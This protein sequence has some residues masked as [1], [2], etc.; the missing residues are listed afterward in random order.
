MTARRRYSTIHKE[1]AMS[2]TFVEGKQEFVFGDAWQVEKYDDHSDYRNKLH[3]LRGSKAV[4]F[5]GILLQSDGY[6]IEV[7]DFRGHEATLKK[8]MKASALSEDIAQK[9]RDSVSGIIGAHRTSSTPGTWRPFARMLADEKRELRIVFWLEDDLARQNPLRWKGRASTLMKEIKC[10]T[11]W[12]T[13]KV[14]VLNQ[15]L[16]GGM[17]HLTVSDLPGAQQT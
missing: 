1:A 3:K 12:L 13:T 9:A 6:L 7:K 17:P 10:Q 11:N 14:L 16:P 5:V 15:V 2:K 4:D 8:R